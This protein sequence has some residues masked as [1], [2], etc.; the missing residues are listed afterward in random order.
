MATTT[1][2]LRPAL[3]RARA[4]WQRARFAAWSRRFSIELRRRK[5][6]LVLDAPHG[7]QL[8]GLP[9]L[10]CQQ[11]GEGD[12]SFTLRIGRNVRFGR[13]VTLV[14]W[15]LGTNVL[16]IGDDTLIDDHVHLHMRGGTVR[17]G[18]AAV[19]RE[20]VVM[21]SEGVLSI[22]EKGNVS[23][24]S[25]IHCKERVDLEDLTVLAEHVTVVDSDHTADGGDEFFLDR[26]LR[27]TPV[28]VGRNTLV[29]S[30]SAVLR[31]A[32]IG[33][34]S[35]VAAGSVV[36]RGDYPDGWLIAGSPAKPV[37]PLGDRD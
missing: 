12:A 30:K 24:G 1:D 2:A 17:V 35:L 9:V 33:R 8:E 18:R 34:N 13:G 25:V 15:A 19:I 22:G 23:H 27:V 20:F 3:R 32:R 7:A 14:V 28:V 21:R 4:G 31:G 29:A 11:V 26:P 36:T 6:R 10:R 16:E 5:G 37:R